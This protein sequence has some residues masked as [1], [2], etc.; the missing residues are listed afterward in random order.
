MDIFSTLTIG[1]EQKHASCI[2]N[3]VLKEW[4]D[5]LTQ[6]NTG[7]DKYGRWAGRQRAGLLNP[8]WSEKIKQV[9]FLYLPPISPHVRVVQGSSLQNYTTAGSNPAAE[10]FMEGRTLVC[11]TASK[12]AGPKG[13]GGSNP[14][15]SAL[16]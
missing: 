1:V 16:S 14:S 8:G 7:A 9:Q 3:G 6:I 11:Y 2:C 5:S 10:S 13:L 4:K 15:P 12:A